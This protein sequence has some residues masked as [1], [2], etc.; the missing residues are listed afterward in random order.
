[1]GTSDSQRAQ[2]AMQ[3]DLVHTSEALLNRTV[4]LLAGWL[5]VVFLCL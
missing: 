3:K 1:M 4:S 5:L 2:E